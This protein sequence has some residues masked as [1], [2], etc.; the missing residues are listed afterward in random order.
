MKTLY[1]F[2]S[3]AGLQHIYYILVIGSLEQ[4]T[5]FFAKMGLLRQGH[6]FKAL[7]TG[8][9]GPYLRCIFNYVSPLVL[10]LYVSYYSTS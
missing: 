5:S 4:V 7:L 9:P 1:K 3:I 10:L 8:T 6:K 2:Q